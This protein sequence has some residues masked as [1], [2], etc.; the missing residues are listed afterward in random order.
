MFNDYEFVYNIIGEKT[1]CVTKLGTKVIP[2]VQDALASVGVVWMAMLELDTRIWNAGCIIHFPEGV[3]GKFVDLV[4]K[5]I[6][7][8]FVEIARLN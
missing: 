3:A 5:S 7:E 2:M 4:E 8:R 6:D 1:V